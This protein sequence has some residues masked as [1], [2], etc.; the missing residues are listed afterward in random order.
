M[1]WSDGLTS[2]KHRQLWTW[3]PN[4]KVA[5]LQKE[6]KSTT[7]EIGNIKKSQMNIFRTPNL[8]R[9]IQKQK[10]EPR[11]EW[12]IGITK[13]EQKTVEKLKKKRKSLRDRGILWTICHLQHWN[14]E[15]RGEETYETWKLLEEIKAETYQIWQEAYTFR[16][17]KQ[18]ELHSKTK[19]P[20]KKYAIVK[21]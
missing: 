10:R 19:E 1:A 15:R 18:L 7:Q 2:Y 13:F 17:K 4:V 9:W 12:K 14:P 6:V 3:K 8:S 5:G 16:Y 20:C 21:L 11:K